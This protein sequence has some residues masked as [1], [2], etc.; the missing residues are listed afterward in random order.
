M[1]YFLSKPRTRESTAPKNQTAKPQIARTTI[2]KAQ[3]AGLTVLRSP[4]E[5]SLR[6]YGRISHSSSFL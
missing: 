5:A 4:D 6:T 1:R 3:P 2:P